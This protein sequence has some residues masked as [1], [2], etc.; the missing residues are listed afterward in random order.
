MDEDAAAI[1]VAQALVPD[2]AAAGLALRAVGTG[3]V[4]IIA[5]GPGLVRLEADQIHAV[6]RLHPAITVAT[7]PDLMRV[8]P[9]AMV[10]TVKIIT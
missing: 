6:N 5:T 2:P 10:A 1:A 4:N 8:D 7:L 9:G 3:R